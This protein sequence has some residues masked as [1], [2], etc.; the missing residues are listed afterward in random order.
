MQEKARAPL[1]IAHAS[2]AAIAISLI[3]VTGCVKKERHEPSTT[4]TAA[5]SPP[6]GEAL[7]TQ[8]CAGC[9]MPSGNGVPNFQPSLVDSPVVAGD[10]ARL[11]NV[12]RG[13][14]F[15]LTDRENPFGTDMPPFGMLS[16]AEM[17]ALLDYLKTNFAATTP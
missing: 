3:L 4:A 8:H 10:R 13:G 11:E 5:S 14:S 15:T 7:Y 17:D 12:I 16:A 9:H 1:V 2:G 6:S